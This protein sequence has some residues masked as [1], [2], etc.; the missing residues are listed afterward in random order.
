MG[1]PDKGNRRRVAGA[2][3]EGDGGQVKSNGR[4][5]A[6]ARGKGDGGQFATLAMGKCGEVDDAPLV[7]CMRGKGVGERVTDK[8]DIKEE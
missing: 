6:G 7:I 4:Q 1:T 8:D 5:A 3:G 2:R